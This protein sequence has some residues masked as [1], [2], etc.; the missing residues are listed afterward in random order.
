MAIAKSSSKTDDRIS[1]LLREVWDRFYPSILWWADRDT[2]IRPESAAE[3][4]REL[5][6]G[7]REALPLA[8]RLRAAM[9]NQDADQR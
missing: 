1:D 5:V 2:M 7:P 8:V 6:S 4:Y 3:V 9:R